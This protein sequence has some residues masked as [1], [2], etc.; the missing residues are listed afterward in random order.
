MIRRRDFITGLGSTAAWPVVARAQQGERMRRVG[1][2]SVGDGTGNPNLAF[3]LQEEL[4]KLGWVEGR[5]LRLE[6]RFGANDEDRIHAYA[7]ELLASPPM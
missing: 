3:A 1:F 4:A 7:A 6:V 5:N 2:L